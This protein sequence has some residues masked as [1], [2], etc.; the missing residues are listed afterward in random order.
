MEFLG[1]DNVSANDG[2][3]YFKDVQAN[4]IPV[5]IIFLDT[6]SNRDSNY[7]RSMAEY[8][9]PYTA[10]AAAFIRLAHTS[11]GFGLNHDGDMLGASQWDWLESTLKSS[12]ADVHIIVSSVQISTSYPVVES[13]GHFK[14][15]RDKLFKIMRKYEPKGLLF[16]SGDVHHAEIS[17]IPF[18]REDNTSG[19]WFEFTSSG[20][21]H[22]CRDNIL[23]NI[24]C[25][26]FLKSYKSH[27]ASSDEYFMNRN[28][29]TIEISKVSNSSCSIAVDV[30]IRGIKT[31]DLLHK[32]I[33]SKCNS[34]S[35]KI[36]NVD[37]F[38]FPV[39]FDISNHATEIV[40]INGILFLG[41]FI[42]L[43]FIFI[44]RK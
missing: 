17:R 21:T 30:S 23:T 6:R 35:A 8:H 16:L 42:V 13:W 44:K 32:R 38:L 24:M 43:N 12:P 3:Y 28:Y 26:L 5:R 7:I 11:L 14:K 19:E 37:Q 36:V 40:L 22:T 33:W 20:M 4:G 15:S 31:E 27:R 39:F 9:F 29:G 1:I 10:L 41:F 2:I 18:M 25:P 34:E